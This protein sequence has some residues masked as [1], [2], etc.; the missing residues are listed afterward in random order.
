[1][2]VLSVQSP[3]A[4]VSLHSERLVVLRHDA[5]HEAPKS[6]VPLGE[7]ERVVFGEGVLVTTP[8]LC[9]LLT[10]QIPVTFLAWN[11]RL[12]GTFEPPGPPRGASRMLQ[13]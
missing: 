5:G 4:Q 13:Y 10:R 9:E 1:M 3:R 2:P 11:G 7:L 6:E 8:A 12:L